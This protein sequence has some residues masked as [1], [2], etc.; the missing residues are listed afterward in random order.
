MPETAVGV[1]QD[2]RKRRYYIENINVS[3]TS[4]HVHVENLFSRHSDAV[5]NYVVAIGNPS[6][7]PDGIA[8]AEIGVSYPA[9]MGDRETIPEI[10]YPLSTCC[11]ESHLE[12]RARCVCRSASW[13]A[14]SGRH[15]SGT[16][17]HLYASSSSL[18]RCS[19]HFGTTIHFRSESTGSASPQKLDGPRCWRCTLLD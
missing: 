7:R 17:R 16:S 13:S 10:I 6:V 9:V 8:G 19:G 5:D 14:F 18:D 11:Y 4:A 15:R 12:G 2:Y 3:N 1:Q